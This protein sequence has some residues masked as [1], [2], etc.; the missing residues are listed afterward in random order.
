[1]EDKMKLVKRTTKDIIGDYIDN[2][3]YIDY[4][5]KTE[6]SP[7]ENYTKAMVRYEESRKTLEL[8]VRNK[9]DKVDH[10]VLEVKRKEHLIDAEVDALKNEIDRL[11]RRKHAV[12]RF[13]DFVN[14]VLLPMVIARVGN[15]AGVWETDVARY[16]LYETYGPVDV[17]PTIC[18]KDFIKVEIKESIDRVKARNAAI[19]ADKAGKALPDGIEIFKVKRV[20]RS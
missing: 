18:S 13:K 1:M 11:K 3:N 9:I 6:D 5:T 4:I 14:K 20:R 8:E 15:E 10:V 12:I 7:S 2:E 17:N 19:S 16:K